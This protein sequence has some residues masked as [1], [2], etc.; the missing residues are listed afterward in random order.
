L[1]PTMFAVVK[2]V[3]FAQMLVSPTMQVLRHVL[4]APWITH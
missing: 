3:Q 1:P 4:F 2:L